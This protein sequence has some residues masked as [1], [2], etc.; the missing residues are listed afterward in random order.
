MPFTFATR[1]ILS[2]KFVPDIFLDSVF[3]VSSLPFLAGMC[4]CVPCVCPIN[5][6]RQLHSLCST[7]VPDRKLVDLHLNSKKQMHSGRDVSKINYCGQFPSIGDTKTTTIFNKKHCSMFLY[8]LTVLQY[9]NK[10][11]PQEGRSLAKVKLN[12]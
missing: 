9:N 10:F 4:V 12:E 6:P 5:Y 3:F 11:K 2:D 1:T 7:N 8:D